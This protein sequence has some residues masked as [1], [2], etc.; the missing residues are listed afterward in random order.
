MTWILHFHLE[1]MTNCTNLDSL[2]TGT[3]MKQE[4]QNQISLSLLFLVTK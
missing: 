2:Q 3:T 1:Q 4:D